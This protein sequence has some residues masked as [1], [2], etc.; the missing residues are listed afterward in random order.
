MASSPSI[1]ILRRERREKRREKERKRRR[2]REKRVNK[3]SEWLCVAL[4][5]NPLT[6][7]SIPSIW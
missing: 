3:E 7:P 4:P 5:T 6:Q 2:E 1:G